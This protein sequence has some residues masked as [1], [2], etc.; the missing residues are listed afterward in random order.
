MRDLVII[1]G[2]FQLDTL[3]AS[4]IRAFGLAQ[5]IKSLGFRVIVMGKFQHAPNEARSAHGVQLDEVTCRDISQPIA[6]RP[7]ASYVVSSEPLMQVVDEQGA[8]SV[9]AIICYNYPARGGWSMIKHARHRGIAPVFDCTE[10][11]GWEGRKVLRNLFRLAGVEVRMRLLT[12]MAGNVICASNWFRERVA[13]QHAVILPFAL[14]T[15]LPKWQR[16]KP[17]NPA[18]PPHFVYCGWPGLGMHKDRLP[19]MFAALADLASAGHAFRITIAGI[20]KSEY[21]KSVP[22][23]VEQISILK[24]RVVFLGRISHAKSLVLLRSADFS[25]FFRKPNRVSNTG[26]STK[27]VEAATLG[28]PVISNPT[29]DIP[30][31]L[32]DGENGILAQSISV[33]HIAEALRRAVELSTVQRIAM[34]TACRDKNPFDMCVWKNEMRD[35]LDKLRGLND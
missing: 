28:L 29:S 18:L 24:S 20:S 7:S 17:P 13:R 32:L 19:V 31:Y 14:D 33:A 23:Q 2:G 26:F 5:L 35:F 11:Y 25:V 3:S 34:V 8:Q 6:G 10:W 21:M 4:A 16:G 15:T 30:L 27:F 1:A 12:R 9:R 22:E